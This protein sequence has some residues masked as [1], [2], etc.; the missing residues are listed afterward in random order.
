MGIGDAGPQLTG[1]SGWRWSCVLGS[2]SGITG[3]QNSQFAL[4]VAFSCSL[5][6]LAS[7]LGWVQ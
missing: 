2:H 7:I 3:P 1:A 4:F 5:G 6:V